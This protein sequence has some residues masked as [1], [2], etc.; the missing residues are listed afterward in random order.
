MSNPATLSRPQRHKSLVIPL[1]GALSAFGPLSIDMYLPS[2]PTLAAEFG[3]TPGQ[4]QLTLSAFFIGFAIGQLVY[5]P[6]S[7]RYGP[8][9]VLLVS[10]GAYGLTSLLCAASPSIEVMTGLRFLQA[11]GGAPVRS[12]RVPWC[13]TCI[14]VTEPRRSYPC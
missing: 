10:L 5:G 4:V 11:L 9:P 14:R 3:A 1:L 12:L 2:L 8:K 6:L 13:G 7:D